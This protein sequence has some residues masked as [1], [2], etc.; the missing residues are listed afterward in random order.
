MNVPRLIRAVVVLAVLLLGSA[1]GGSASALSLRTGPLVEYWDG[2]SWAQ[3]AV[4][5]VG[6]TGGLDAVVAPAAA[7]V[8]AFGSSRIA[9]H[10]DGA[11][12]QRVSLPVPKG[13]YSPQIIGAAALSSED[14]WAVGGV[15]RANGPEQA[16]I[17]HWNGS[18]WQLVPGPP[19]NRYGLSGVAALSAKNVWAVGETGVSTPTG[20]GLRTLTIHWNGKAWKRVPSPNPTTSMT[21]SANFNDTLAAVAGSSARDVWAVGQYYVTANGT[22]GSRSLVLHWDGSSWKQVLTPDPL[23]PGHASSLNGVAAPSARGVWAVGSVNRRGAGHAL[24]EF[25]NGARWRIVHTVGAPLA[26][27]SA[28]GADDAWAAGS[29][30]GVVADVMYWNGNAWTVKTKL[31]PS[32]ELV[33]VAEVSPTDVWGVGGLVN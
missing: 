29:G 21:S 13:S 18:R 19:K 30:G 15:S 9:V 23:T 11:S 3:V 33:A 10:W 17:D 12:W 14:I 5:S 27:V 20:G 6:T 1:L 25:W 7:D 22:R 26:G 8:W 2:T 16:L 32:G 24:T 4:P 28:L 31:D